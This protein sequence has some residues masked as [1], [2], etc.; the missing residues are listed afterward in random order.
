MNLNIAVS[1]TTNK[2]IGAIVG[3]ISA[4]NGISA[5]IKNCY[6]H[7]YVEGQEETVVSTSGVVVGIFGESVGTNIQGNYK[8][9]QE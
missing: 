1:N 4:Y 5:E 8:K 3:R 6:S 9:E 2:Y 7:V